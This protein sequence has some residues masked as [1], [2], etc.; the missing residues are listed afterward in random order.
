MNSLLNS[1]RQQ[2][3]FIWSKIMAAIK[4]SDLQPVGSEFFMGEENFISE[5]S[6]AD[7]K[8]VHGGIISP[9]LP[10]IV[11]LTPLLC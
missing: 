9:F 8:G 4:I 11:T 10:S 2:L 1:Q 5:L 6:D 3:L 7:L